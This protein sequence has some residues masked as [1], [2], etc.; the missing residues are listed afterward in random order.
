VTTSLRVA[1]AAAIGISFMFAVPTISAPVASAL[2]CSI[3][4]GHFADWS[5]CQACMGNN[6]YDPPQRDQACG[7]TGQQIQG[8]PAPLAPY[9]SAYDRSLGECP[10]YPHN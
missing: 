10:D 9:C 8:P 5:A 1:A 2:P 6:G 4:G 7:L 3:V